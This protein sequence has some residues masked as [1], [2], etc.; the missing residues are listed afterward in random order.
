[1]LEISRLEMDLV[2][3]CKFGKQQGCTGEGK[4]GL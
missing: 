1:M 4:H 2:F 3:K